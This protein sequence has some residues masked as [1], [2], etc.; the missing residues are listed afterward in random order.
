MNYVTERSLLHINH[1]VVSY[2]DALSLV[3]FLVR[4]A[5]SALA[6]FG[7]LTAS[8]YLAS[9]CP[10]VS[11]STLPVEHARLSLPPSG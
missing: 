8:V 5:V 3:S 6:N 7:V 9:H 1:A 2:F 11:S 10:T 4:D